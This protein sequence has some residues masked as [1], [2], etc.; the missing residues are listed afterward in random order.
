M[1]S[2]FLALRMIGASCIINILCRCEAA[3]WSINMR[4]DL[5]STLQTPCIVIDVNKAK[6]NIKK[7][8][9]QIDK[10]NCVLRPHIKTHKMIKFAKMQ[11][12][13]GA[14]GITCAKLS[15]AEIMADGGIDD[16]FIA[17]PIIGKAKTNR[18]PALFSKVKRL[19][20]AV[21]SEIGAKG[22]SECAQNNNIALEIRLEVDTG[23]KRTGVQENIIE[24]AKKINA[25]PNLNLNGIFTFKSLVYNQKATTDINLAAKEEGDLMQEIAIKL[26]EVGISI[27]DIS[28]GSTP[29]GMAV[30]KTGKINETRPGTYIF[31]DYMLYKEGVYQ[32][33]D[34]AAHI[35]ATVVSTPCKEYAVI[36]GGTKTFPMDI[37]LNSPPYYYDSYAQVKDHAHL[38]LTR[39]NEEHGIIT[40]D[41]GCTILNVG[42]VIK[43]I[44]IHIC[45]AIN[46]QNNVYLYENDELTLSKIDA[47]GALI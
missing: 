2:S 37:F 24:L 16:I 12:D 39:M 17:Y 41:N 19:I 26:H 5:L 35:Y 13:A 15:E 11:I 8:Q 1:L 6:D 34:I 23:A 36:D 18:I 47:R 32:I 46:L 45:T 10:T 29:T 7:M 40:S 33:D 22:L 30:A 3:E 20:L 14:I 21:D 44:P 28:A 43:L 4:D 38:H 31:S 25:M 9:D 27:S 42:D